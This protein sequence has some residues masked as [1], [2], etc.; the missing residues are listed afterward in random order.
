MIFMG[1]FMQDNLQTRCTLLLQE[2]ALLAEGA[3]CNATPY[4]AVLPVI[5]PRLA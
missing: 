5:L 3:S 2:L 4:Q 1:A